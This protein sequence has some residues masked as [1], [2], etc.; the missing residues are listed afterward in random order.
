VWQSH[1]AGRVEGGFEEIEVE[2][3]RIYRAAD[4]LA[5]LQDAGI[6]ATGRS[7]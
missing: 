2:P 7:I 1:R 4:A 5:F 6:D 3:T